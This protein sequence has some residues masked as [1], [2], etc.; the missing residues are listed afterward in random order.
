MTDQISDLFSILKKQLKAQGLTYKTLAQKLS[1]SEASIKRLFSQQDAN[2]SRLQSICACLNLSL[3][4]VFELLQKD[5]KLIVH[6]TENQEKELVS[7]LRLLLVAIC[8]LNHWTFEDILR[9]YTISEHELIRYAAKLD[10]MK[11]IELQPGNR[12]KRLIA[13]DFHWIADGP[14]Q[15][16]F[17]QTIQDDFFDCQFE[18]PTELFLVRSGML[19]EQDNRIF[20]QT[21]H[22]TANEFVKRCRDTVDVPIDKRHGTALIIAMRPWVPRIFDNLKRQ[23]PEE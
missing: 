15:R 7:E 17:Q 13:P 8:V 10:K 14:I 9:F 5:K 16:F 2:L 18:K 12:F 11:I 1:L 21:L 3:S 22:N 6:L 4:E 23:I 20:Q 19:S